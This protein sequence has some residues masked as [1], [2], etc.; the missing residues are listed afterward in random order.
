MVTSPSVISCLLAN[1]D[2]DEVNLPPFHRPFQIPV[3]I[4]EYQLHYDERD[5]AGSSIGKPPPT[6]KVVFLDKPLPQ[7]KYTPRELN[8]KYVKY[9]FLEM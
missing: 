8:E 1:N 7:Y 3:I 6:H 9:A 2:C 5:L 4:K